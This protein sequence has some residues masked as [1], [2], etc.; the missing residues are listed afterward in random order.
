VVSGCRLP[1]AFRTV[2]RRSSSFEGAELSI[3]LRAESPISEAVGYC[4]VS[5]RRP[6]EPRRRSVH[7]SANP[8]PS[9]PAPGQIGSPK[10]A[11]N[12]R[13]T[14]RAEIPRLQGIFGPHSGRSRRR[15]PSQGIGRCSRRLSDSIRGSAQSARPPHATRN[16]VRFRRP[17]FLCLGP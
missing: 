5:H 17:A 10:G 11:Q 4:S 9:R 2:S 13:S 15:K 14:R 1:S 7:Y 16:L 3:G 8:A 12:A 6:T